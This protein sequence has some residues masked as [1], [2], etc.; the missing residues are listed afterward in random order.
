MPSMPGTRDV[1]PPASK[2]GATSGM[3]VMDGHSGPVVGAEGGGRQALGAEEVADLVVGPGVADGHRLGDL[4][5]PDLDLVAPGD[6]RLGPDELAVA[7]GDGEPARLID[8][9]GLETPPAHVVERDDDLVP[10]SGHR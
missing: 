10:L 9:E 8:V 2:P 6:P 7:A 1:Q 5:G 3:D 4:V